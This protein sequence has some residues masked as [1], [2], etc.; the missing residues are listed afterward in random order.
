MCVTVVYVTVWLQLLRQQA[1][2][3]LCE[4]STLIVKLI[5]LR[6]GLS[7]DPEFND[8]SRLAGQ[9][10]QG[11]LESF[12]LGSHT[13]A[14][15]PV[16]NWALDFQ[17]HA[18]MVSSGHCLSEPSLHLTLSVSKTFIIAYLGS[19]SKCFP[20]Q[21]SWSSDLIRK[22]RA[23]ILSPMGIFWEVVFVSFPR[24]EKRNVLSIWVELCRGHF[25]LW[26]G[27]GD[28]CCLANLLLCAALCSGWL[29]MQAQGSISACQRALCTQPSCKVPWTEILTEE[30]C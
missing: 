22:D 17:A 11:P 3:C 6:L 2:G 18:V 16:F 28:P 10:T 30:C 26:A 14:V 25:S 15:A 19:L 8:L 7:L 20:P 24:Q 12:L 9:W 29:L 13:H 4:S 23:Y 21:L 1:K 5:L 27:V